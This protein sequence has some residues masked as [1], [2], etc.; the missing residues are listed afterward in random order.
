MVATRGLSFWLEGLPRLTM[1]P[2]FAISA[3]YRICFR[4]GMLRLNH[5]L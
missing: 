4:I 3:H 1:T 5:G 2:L